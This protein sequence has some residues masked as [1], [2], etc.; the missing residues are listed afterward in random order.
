VL[1]ILTLHVLSTNLTYNQIIARALSLE[2]EL[3]HLESD[4]QRGGHSWNL[5]FAQAL[6]FVNFLLYSMAIYLFIGMVIGARLGHVFFYEASYYISNPVEILKIWQ[7]G[8]ASHGAAIGVFLAY[9][10]WISVHKIKFTNPTPI[11]ILF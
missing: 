9:L 1:C 2:Q 8:L 10:I 5:I 6:L 7:G 4:S 3:T 11:K